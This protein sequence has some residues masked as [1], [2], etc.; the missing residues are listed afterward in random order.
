[1]IEKRA[2]GRKVDFAPFSS[3]LSLSLRSGVLSRIS[4]KLPEMSMFL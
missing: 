2:G 4:G 3:S 1:M